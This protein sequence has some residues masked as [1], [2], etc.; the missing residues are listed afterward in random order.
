MVEIAGR[1]NLAP[2]ATYVKDG[3]N[4][5]T[6]TPEQLKLEEQ[7]LNYYYQIIKGLF[8]L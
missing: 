8:E 6:S 2:C 3:M 1:R 5:K 4:I 7:W